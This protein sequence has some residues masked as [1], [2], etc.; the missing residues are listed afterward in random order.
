[1]GTA[2]DPTL[3]LEHQPSLSA[4]NVARSRAIA[5]HDPR[6]EIR[7]PDTLAE[8][9]LADDPVTLAAAQQSLSNPAL[10]AA[11]LQKIAAFSPG[12][13][14]FFI[15]RTAYLDEIV[16]QALRDNLPQIVLLGAGYDTRAFRFC[17]LIRQTRLFELDSKATQQR[18]RSLLEQAQVAIPV[19]LTFVTIDFT[20]DRLADKLHEAG[21]S[22]AQPTL[23]IWEGVSYYLPA[24]A[25][26]DMLSFVRQHSPAG[27]VIA[28]DYMI[29]A[30]D[31]AGRFGAQQARTAMQTAYTAEPLRFDLKESE[32]AAF[33]AARG[34]D[35][36]DHPTT[37]ELQR[38]YLTLRDGSSA[39]PMLDLFRLVQAAVRS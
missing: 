24:Q 39:G 27:S 34:F 30:S 5:A 11:M 37:D 31:L 18:K 26:D 9:F 17:H 38:R 13:Y 15:V 23:F 14:E 4:L 1:M 7:G 32:T 25:V 36:I 10:H 35:L 19:A 16:A 8:I 21:F 29:A 6:E 22:E 20:R 28:F 2:P 33:L 3:S 12:G